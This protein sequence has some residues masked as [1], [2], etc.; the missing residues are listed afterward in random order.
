MRSVIHRTQYHK[1]EISA[2]IDGYVHDALHRDILR[3]KLL[4][5]PTFDALAAEKELDVSTVKRIYYSY[6]GT[7]IGKYM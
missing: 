1:D 2:A 5:N 6:R 7:K 3:R 4:D